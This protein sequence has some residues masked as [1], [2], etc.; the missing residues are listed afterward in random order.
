MDYNLRGKSNATSFEDTQ[1][2]LKLAHATPKDIFC[3]LGC[4]NG[5]VCRW[6]S[7]KVNF[8]Y[9]VEEYKKRYQTAISKIKKHH[10]KQ[11]VYS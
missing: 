10:H 3:D 4:G 8:V 2:I 6:A 9:G 5:N 1:I 11:P 7:K